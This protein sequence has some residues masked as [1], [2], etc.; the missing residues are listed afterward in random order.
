ML[1]PNS[2]RDHELWPKTLG[3]ILFT[4]YGMRSMTR[5]VHNNREQNPLLALS[6]ALTGP[7]Q[8]VG[9][10][11]RARH[12]ILDRDLEDLDR[13]WRLTGHDGLGKRLSRRY[14][15]SAPIDTRC[16]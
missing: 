14:V 16:S 11:Q 15:E 4:V 2:A 12:Y 1:V 8:A 9:T 10:K 7:F 13:R 5:F 6:I 3:G